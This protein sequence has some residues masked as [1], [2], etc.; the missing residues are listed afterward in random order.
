MAETIKV[1]VVIEEV[2]VDYEAS[3]NGQYRQYTKDEVELAIKQTVKAALEL[4]AKRNLTP[5]KE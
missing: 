1:R 5:A 3:F 4:H 2:V